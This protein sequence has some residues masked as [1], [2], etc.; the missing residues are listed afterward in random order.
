MKLQ[1]WVGCS[2]ATHPKVCGLGHGDDDTSAGRPGANRGQ[3]RASPCP[4]RQVLPGVCLES[5]PGEKSLESRARGAGSGE[6]GPGTRAGEQ[7][8]G[9]RAWG[10]G[11]GSRVR[12]AGPGEQG[13]GAGPGSRPGWHSRQGMVP[14]ST[15]LGPK[16][17]VV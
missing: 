17:R 6:Q 1:W 12:R 4:S 5:R 16:R 3:P 10:A 8:P 9:S 15:G 11:L 2:L 7:G 14:R 13:R